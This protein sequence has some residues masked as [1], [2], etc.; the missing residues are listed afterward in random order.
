MYYYKQINTLAIKY[1]LMQLI[2]I[3]LIREMAYLSKIRRLV[4]KFHISLDQ[5]Q[6]KCIKFSLY[7]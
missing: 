1:L 3:K 7:Y 4:K 6:D 5:L 2:N